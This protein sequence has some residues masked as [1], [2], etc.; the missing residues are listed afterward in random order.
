MKYSRR[1]NVVRT[2]KY[3]KY[4]E[5]ISIVNKKVVTSYTI[6]LLY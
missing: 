6:F 1:S 4:S 5:K 2:Y 3:F